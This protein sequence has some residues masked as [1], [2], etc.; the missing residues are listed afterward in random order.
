MKRMMKDPERKGKRIKKFAKTT[1]K[2]MVGK[3]KKKINNQ[4]RMGITKICKRRTDK[5]I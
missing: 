1:K 3:G 2:K 5:I 4:R